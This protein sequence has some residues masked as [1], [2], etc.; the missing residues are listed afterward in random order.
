M[1][2]NSSSSILL[3]MFGMLFWCAVLIISICMLI[4]PYTSISSDYKAQL[5]NI[6]ISVE[7]TPFKKTFY[8]KYAYYMD[9]GYI[10]NNEFNEL[11]N[12]YE[13]YRI[14]VVSNADVKYIKTQ[15]DLM[16]SQLKQDE[17][18]KEFDG[19]YGILLRLFFVTGIIAII[20][21]FAFRKVKGY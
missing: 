15:N 18:V 1:S 20:P 12:M 13:D 6:F 2:D 7:K 3:S 9:N 19:K 14:S 4:N 8:D 10:S 11:Q 16:E 17:N 5:Q 21:F